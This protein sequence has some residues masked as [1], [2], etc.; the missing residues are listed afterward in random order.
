MVSTTAIVKSKEIMGE[1]FL[2]SQILT[3]QSALAD[4]KLRG[5]NLFHLTLYT[6]NKWPL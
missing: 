1:V 2:E 4:M 6:A 3:V 5:W